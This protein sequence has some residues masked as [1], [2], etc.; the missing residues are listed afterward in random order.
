M[1]MIYLHW[2]T[3]IKYKINY[4]KKKTHSNWT[5]KHFWNYRYQLCNTTVQVEALER[6]N[7]L[8]SGDNH[9]TKKHLNIKKNNKVSTF[10]SQ[11][12]HFQCQ[13]LFWSD[14]IRTNNQYFF[15]IL[16]EKSFTVRSN[17]WSENT[18]VLCYVIYKAQ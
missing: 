2:L 13:S 15:I 7:I 9:L 3:I 12:R 11:G 18:N 10:V 14:F 1:N 17:H 5:F 16:T 4:E 8:F 6:S